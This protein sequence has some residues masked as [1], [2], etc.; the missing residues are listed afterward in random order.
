MNLTA[1]LETV[2][3]LSFIYLLLSLFCSGL[4]EMVAQRAGRRGRFLR[5]GLVNLIADRWVYLRLINHPLIA[6]LYRDVPDKP[7]TP[8]Y[9]PAQ[10]FAYALLD[11]VGQKAAQLDPQ[12]APASGANKGFEDVRKSAAICRDHGYMVGQTL[13][14]LLDQADG[15]LD[16]ARG[17]IEGWF[18]SGTQRI[19]GWYKAA[20]RR[21]LLLIGFMVAVTFNVDTLQVTS[22]ITRNAG[23]R[24]SLADQAADVA[25]SGE[26]AG[27][28][29]EAGGDRSLTP[30]QLQEITDRLVAIQ[31]EGVPFGFSCLGPAS[32]E[33]GVKK[34]AVDADSTSPGKPPSGV[35]G[36]CLSNA[37]DIP[38][39][40][41]P[42][43]LLGWLITALAISFGAP[44]WF[45]LLNKFVDLRGAG[46]KP[47]TPSDASVQTVG[48][49][50]H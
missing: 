40:A 25:G 31:A 13:L 24:R 44:F 38:A 35:F 23:L 29:V 18:E 49:A 5:E 11:V 15:S 6:S 47:A 19:S 32:T 12:Q 28:D 17:L 7:A 3:A 20:T 34:D 8:S 46:K 50:P 41:W 22:T 2:I 1:I 30:E 36:R 43:K 45:D 26:I 16:R 9:V 33:A 39:G 10:N 4:N 48:S 37:G 14:T 27:V 42:L 21:S